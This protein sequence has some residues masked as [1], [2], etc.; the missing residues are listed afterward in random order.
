MIQFIP[1][2][3]SIY[4]YFI[5]DCNFELLNYDESKSNLQKALKI[6]KSNIDYNYIKGISYWLL[7]R[8]YSKANNKKKALSL[9]EKSATYIQESLLYSTIAFKQI[10]LKNY[11]KALE[12]SNKAILT[13]NR[14]AYVSNNRALVC[15]KRK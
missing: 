5:S 9:F 3:N 10:Q 15:L 11:D 12:S 14:N 13:D 2:K 7:G 1:N 8:I 4:Y 6:K